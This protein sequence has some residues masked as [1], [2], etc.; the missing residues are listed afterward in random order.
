MRHQGGG[1]ELAPIGAINSSDCV[2]KEGI[3]LS[4]PSRWRNKVL[5]RCEVTVKDIVIAGF[6]LLAYLGNAS[7]H[8]IR[9][10]LQLKVDLPPINTMLDTRR[11]Q[12]IGP[13]DSLLDFGIIGFNRCGTTSIRDWLQ[14][15]GDHVVFGHSAPTLQSQSAYKFSMQTYHR[16]KGRVKDMN[17]NRRGFVNKKDRKVTLKSGMKSQML[18]MSANGPLAIS[19]H[20]NSTNL[21]VNIRHPIPWFQSFYNDKWK[22]HKSDK[23]RLKKLGR[24]GRHS[25]SMPSPWDLV[26]CKSPYTQ[27]VCGD[28]AEFH[29]F[30]A[31][32]QKTNLNTKEE[33]HILRHYGCSNK[34]EDCN[35]SDHDDM[36]KP[37]APFGGKIFLTEITQLFAKKEEL[38]KD[39][40]IF[41]GLQLPDMTP[42]S[43]KGL[44]FDKAI[45]ICDKQYKD[46]RDVLLTR[47][48]RV[49]RW[50]LDY[51]IQSEDV[52]VSSREY[53]TKTLEDWNK[54][55]CESHHSRELMRLSEEYA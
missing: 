38:R 47:A 52:V 43:K 36:L 33:M 12:I 32:L 40:G 28:K 17:E 29:R 22:W 15:A 44:V 24:L 18:L 50:I 5:C 3:P 39:L 25:K 48:A 54:D 6:L 4:E 9:S 11:K 8:H 37:L 7:Y 27:T 41:L 30:L 34:T 1:F 23:R 14:K 35:I 16:L 53:F 2:E 19:Q 13:V 45:N 42:L 51:F 46:I 26:Q 55:P 49:S 21:I 20:F 31:R 10:T